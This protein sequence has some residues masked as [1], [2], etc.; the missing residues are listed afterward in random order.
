MGRLKVVKTGPLATVQD[1]GRFGYRRYGIP[2]SGA[3]DRGWMIA[4]NRL[5]GNP[6]NNPVI[7]FALAGI[8]L[9]AIEESFVSVVGAKMNV[10]GLEIRE[11]STTLKAGDKLKISRPSLKYAYL[12]IAGLLQAQK[13]FG[14]YATYPRAGFGGVDGRALIKGDDLI[15]LGKVNQPKNGKPAISKDFNKSTRVRIMKGPEWDVLKEIPSSKTFHVDPSSDRMGIRLSGRPIEANFREIVS[16]AVIPGTVQLPP[17]GRPIIL[18][19]DCQTTGGYPRIGKV[20]EEDMWL[21]SQITSPG[22]IY[23]DLAD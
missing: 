4:A 11:L 2:Q 13:D 17:D 12:A 15:T 23:L 14:S 10:N 19:N 7:E 1:F 16:S 20:L 22:T 21:L 8:E 3:M 5:V 9:I 18:M 6:E